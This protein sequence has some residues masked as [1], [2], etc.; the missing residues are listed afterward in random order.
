MS[1]QRPDAMI[2]LAHG[3]P[4]PDW[5][6]PVEATAERIR[7]AHPPPFTVLTAVLEHGPTLAEAVHRLRDGGHRHIAVVSLFLSDAGRHLRRDIP[8]MITALQTTFSSVSVQLVPG[9]LG[10]D[11]VVLDALAD[12]AVRRSGMATTANPDP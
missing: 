11:D 4:D 1:E 10:T 8:A 3:S 6:A 7:R 9:A 5:M 12:A 2:L